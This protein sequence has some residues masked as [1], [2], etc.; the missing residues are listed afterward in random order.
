MTTAT[1]RQRAVLVAYLMTGSY[2][3]AAKQLG[4]N[5]AT[6]RKWVSELL[7]ANGW[8]NVAQAAFELGREE[9]RT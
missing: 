6:C 2:K 8:E 3:A 4:M 7:K 9:R 1:R 5:E